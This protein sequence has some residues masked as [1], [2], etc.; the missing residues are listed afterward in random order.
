MQKM[1]NQKTKSKIMITYMIA[2]RMMTLIQTIAMSLIYRARIVEMKVKAV[3]E[4]KEGK[5]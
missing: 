5:Q 2:R 1:N 4:N 3:R